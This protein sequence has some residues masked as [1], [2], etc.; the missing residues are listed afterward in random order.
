MRKAVRS[1]E[2]L[3]EA[4]QMILAELDQ[5]EPKKDGSDGDETAGAEKTEFPV[6]VDEPEQRVGLEQQ[7]MLKKISRQ[8]RYRAMM[9]P[10]DESNGAS[11][12]ENTPQTERKQFPEQKLKRREARAVSAGVDGGA[13]EA[14][15]SIMV[16]D[17]RRNE[18]TED[19]LP[20]RLSEVYR[21][22]ARRYDGTFER[23]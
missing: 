1:D 6:D 13:D 7:N 14:G 15:D 11:E 22:D 9:E 12:R 16:T 20:F 2:E 10:E 23:Y 19:G 18:L 8:R 4:A 17:V 3:R 5:T 21:R